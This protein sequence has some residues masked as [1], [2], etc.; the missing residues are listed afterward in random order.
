MPARPPKKNPIHA[1]GPQKFFLADR[2][3]RRFTYNP[4]KF[5]CLG[6]DSGNKKK[7]YNFQ[8]DMF[9]AGKD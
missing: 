8:S 4:K 5:N 1:P 6:N 3:L 2:L 9:K 7:Q